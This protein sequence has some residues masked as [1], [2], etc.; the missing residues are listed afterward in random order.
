MFGTILWWGGFD[1]FNHNIHL[2]LISQ[3]FSQRDNRRHKSFTKGFTLNCHIQW[4]DACKFYKSALVFQNKVTTI[5]F[6]FFTITN[7]LSTLAH[8]AVADFC[9]H[10]CICKIYSCLHLLSEEI[11]FMSPKGWCTT[12]R[13]SS[14]SYE[15]RWFV[16]TCNLLENS[17]QVYAAFNN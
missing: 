12:G 15:V 1:Y 2:C 3:I 7:P 11:T 10:F 9:V 13:L 8:A 14:W 5:S 6:W 17:C 16:S 4:P